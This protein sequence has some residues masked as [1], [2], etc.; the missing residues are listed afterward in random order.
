MVTIQVKVDSHL[1][2]TIHDD[3]VGID[4]DHI[5]PFSNGLTNI[6]KRMEE[7]GGKAAIQ[8]RDGTEII[9]DVPLKD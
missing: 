7:I 5:R 2:V 6:Q 8:N 1:K 9:L 3:G 4:W